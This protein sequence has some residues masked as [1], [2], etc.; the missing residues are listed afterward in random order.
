MSTGGHFFLKIG[1]TFFKLGQKIILGSIK[2]AFLGII[3]TPALLTALIEDILE[4]VNG[5]CCSLIRKSS[6]NLQNIR[7]VNRT[8]LHS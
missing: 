7:F 1:G 6:V 5:F 4:I 3:L 8:L 2:S